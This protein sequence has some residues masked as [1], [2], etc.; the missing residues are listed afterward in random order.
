V[1]DEQEQSDDRGDGER[2]VPPARQ[3]PEREQQRGD[4]D[5]RV[6]PPEWSSNVLVE[7]RR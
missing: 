1:T 6:P 7:H 4:G 3:P 5:D 2:L